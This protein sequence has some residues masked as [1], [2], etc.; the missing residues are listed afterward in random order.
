M[1]CKPVTPELW[2]DMETL[3]GE[4]GA[5]GGCWCM[6]WRI[7]RKD[8]EKQQGEQN[9]EAMKA[10]VLSNEVPGIL[11]YIDDKP[12]AW[13]SVAPREAFPVLD[14][15]P[16]LK[17]VDD[18]P[19]WS[20]VCFFIEKQHRRRGLSSLLLSSVLDYAKK[21]GGT[22]VEAYPVVPKKERAPDMYLFT[23]LVST[24]EKA[25][26]VEVCR[27]SRLRPIMRYTL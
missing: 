20:I 1:I 27:R 7:K 15:S 14:R 22:I 5:L 3:F 6:W 10:I 9:R 25:G 24:F 4:H 8:F 26:F 2:P 23:G 11:G 21:E 12:V 19:V 17:R 16:I 13:C 18:K